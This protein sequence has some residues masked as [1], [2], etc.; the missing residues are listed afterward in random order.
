[1]GFEKGTPENQ[2]A[3]SL[4]EDTFVIGVNGVRNAKVVGHKEGDK[5]E[6]WD[7]R[8]VIGVRPEGVSPGHISL[9]AAHAPSSCGMTQMWFWPLVRLNQGK[10]CESQRYALR[11]RFDEPNGRDPVAVGITQI[12]S[13]ALGMDYG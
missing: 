1:M 3:D 7:I 2:I 8:R 4:P 6:W 10:F 13:V 9:G 11:S 12:R 5:C